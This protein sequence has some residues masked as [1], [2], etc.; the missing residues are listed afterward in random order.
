M[1]SLDLPKKKS[2]TSKNNATAMED[3]WISLFDGKTTAGWHNYGKKTV[4]KAWRVEDG[5]LH[6]DAAVKKEK[7]TEGGDLLTDDEF[8]NFHLKWEWK[9]SSKGNSGVL[10]YVHEDPS[11]HKKTYQSGMEM[12]IL[13]NGTPIRAGHADAK[14]YTHRAGDLYDLLASKE[15]VMPQGEWN[16]AEIIANKGNLDFY[17]NG[18]HTL[19]TV[20][21]NDDWTQMINISKFE[22]MVDF[23]TY[24]KGRIALQ[25]HGDDVWYR[26]IKI[27]RL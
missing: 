13:D 9:I 10:F 5:I 1:F 11:K 27:K 8:E 22:D 6:F 3:K 19:S 23:G 12:Q 21:W 24:K 26:N 16:L 15:E 2:L 18:V 20:M 4:G 14:S 25:D 7:K 17:L